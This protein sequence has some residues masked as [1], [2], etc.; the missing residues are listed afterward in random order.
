MC[1]ENEPPERH[2]VVNVLARTAFFG[3]AAALV[4]YVAVRF[5][6]DEP[7]YAPR[8]ATYQG[9][10]ALLLSLTAVIE[11]AAERRAPGWKRDLAA[12]LLALVA[13]AL[14][15]LVAPFEGHYLMSI[16]QHGSLTAALDEMHDY[17]RFVVRELGALLAL[18]FVYG[19]PLGPL[20]VGRLRGWRLLPQIAACAVVSLALV[21]PGFLVFRK[22]RTGSLTEYGVLHFVEEVGPTTILAPLLARAAD[23]VE[24]AYGR[25]RGDD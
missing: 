15:G 25:W 2:P 14:L 20:A 16:I 7:D 11:L 8:A 12:G 23:L 6:D 21:E 22:M 3:A 24:R 5:L 10:C 1:A 9:L 4:T 17:E 18:R 13:A 19:T